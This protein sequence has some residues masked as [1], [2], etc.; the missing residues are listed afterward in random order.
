[1]KHRMDKIGRNDPCPCGS[2]LKYKKCC[3]GKE[4]RTESAAA[5]LMPRQYG[6]DPE[7]TTLTPLVIVEVVEQRG[8]RVCAFG[9]RE[10]TRITTKAHRNLSL[11]SVL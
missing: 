7:L 8:H 6:I 3:L 5:E 11:R 1:M 10:P 2:G 4:Q 9:R